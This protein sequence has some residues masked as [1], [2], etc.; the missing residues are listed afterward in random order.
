MVWGAAGQGPGLVPA[1]VR[2]ASAEAWRGADGHP[3]S[4]PPH[5]GI[6]GG[7]GGSVDKPWDYTGLIPGI[8]L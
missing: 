1:H 4:P 3:Q 5:A 2:P 7:A 8:T 6:N